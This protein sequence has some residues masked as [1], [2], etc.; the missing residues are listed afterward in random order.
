MIKDPR[1]L[2]RAAGEA[3]TSS[4]SSDHFTVGVAMNFHRVRL[5]ALIAVVI[6]GTGAIQGIWTNRWNTSRALSELAQRIDQIPTHLGSWSSEPMVMDPR[7]LELAGATCSLARRYTHESTGETV[8]MLLLAGLPAQI[9]AH[10]PEVCYPAAGYSLSRTQQR[11]IQSGE[12]Q[13]LVNIAT[14]TASSV[15]APTSSSRLTLV[16]CWNDGNGWNTP[17]NARMAYMNRSALCKLY[18]V[19][20]A[21][22]PQTPWDH[23]DF[24]E[25]VRELLP[26]AHAR[27]FGEETV[28]SVP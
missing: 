8:S 24:A 4:K 15:D 12:L 13:S 23:T 26:E 9:S 14:A 5:F 28:T 7:T 10:T 11:S 2:T 3:E 20:S 27:L 1:I 21:T 19:S 17:S 25:L 6:L 18:L 16:W 22:A